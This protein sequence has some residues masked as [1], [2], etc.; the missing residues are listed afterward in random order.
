MEENVLVNS[1]IKERT[2]TRKGIFL[3]FKRLMDI[4]FSI[5]GIV[6]LIPILLI[7]KICYMISGDFKSII[8]KQNRIGLNGKEFKFYKIRTM[9]PN[10]EQELERLMKEDKKIAEEY[11]KYKKLHND[12]RVTKGGNFLRKLSIDEFPQFINIFKGDMSLIGPRP[13]LPRE[14]EDMKKSYNEIITCKPGLTGYW[15]VNGRSNT[16]FNERIDLDKYYVEHQSFKLDVKLFFKTFLKLL[17]RDGA[18]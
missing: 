16:D 7:T 10:A 5:V 2:I 12:P 18:K 6:F 3:C 13:Y 15:Q 4:L 14:K 11:K 17:G 8:F 1:L 9:I